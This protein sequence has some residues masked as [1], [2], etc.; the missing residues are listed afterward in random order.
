M[1]HIVKNVEPNEFIEW[2]NKANENW[3]LTFQS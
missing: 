3:Q 1:K 2:K